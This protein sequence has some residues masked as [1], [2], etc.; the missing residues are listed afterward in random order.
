MA[1][2]KSASALRSDL[3]RKTIYSI[4]DIQNEHLIIMHK[5]SPMEH[6]R[7]GLLYNFTSKV[8]LTQLAT[9]LINFNRYSRNSSSS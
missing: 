3:K 9:S 2:K 8:L 5:K 4:I 7:C 1:K 6:T